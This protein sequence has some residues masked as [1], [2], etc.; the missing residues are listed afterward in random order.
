MGAT[1]TC[2]PNAL[3]SHNFTP[4]FPRAYSSNTAQLICLTVGAS[5]FC[6]YA[7]FTGT[8]GTALGARPPRW[9]LQCH[10]IIFILLVGHVRSL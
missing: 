3:T 5:A 6:P 9:A 2:L 10:N 8:L 1:G 7:E 4:R